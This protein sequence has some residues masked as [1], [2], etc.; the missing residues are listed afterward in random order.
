MQ[1]QCH[2]CGE[3]FEAKRSH[4]KW[5]SAACRKQ[6]QRAPGGSVTELRRPS[7]PEAPGADFEGFGPVALATWK[8]LEDADRVHEPEGVA[9]LALAHRLD[10][11]GRDTGSALAS[12]ARELRATLEVALKGANV[13][14]DPLDELRARREA[15]LAGNG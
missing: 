1:I 7:A 4:A 15:R 2:N 5:C 10:N 14:A 12:V 11:G 13:A 9:A 8:K 3:S 6:S